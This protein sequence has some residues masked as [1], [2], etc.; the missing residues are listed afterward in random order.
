MV[1]DRDFQLPDQPTRA[2]ISAH[3]NDD[4][5]QLALQGCRDASVDM[6]MA[7]QQIDGY[8]RSRQKLPSW[9]ET[10]GLV[11]P[12]HLSMEQCSS[13]MTAHYKQQLAA[14]WKGGIMADLTGGFGVDFAHLATQFERAVYVER[15]QSLCEIASHNFKLLGLNHAEVVC[16]DAIEY[17]ST[18]DNHFDLL[19]IDPARRD[20]HGRKTFDLADCTPDISRHADTLLAKADRVMVKLSPM[21]DWHRA[22]A[23]LPSVGEVHIVATGNECKELLIVMDK[24]ATALTVTCKN[25]DEIF[26]FCPQGSQ[27][28][29][30]DTPVDSV[31]EW[32]TPEAGQ[33]LFVPN[34]AIMKAGCFDNLCAEYHLQ[35]LT[36]NSHLYTK[37]TPVAAFPG[38][39]F[40]LK[41]VTSL[42]KKSLRQALGGITRANIATRNFPM[43][44]QQLRSRLKLADG[45]DTYLFATTL[46]DG[47]HVVL[48]AEKPTD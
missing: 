5:R 32:A 37:D 21:F 23:E 33:Y 35:A 2:F 3:R 26:V 15:Q 9:A 13:E 39:T 43:T 14:R 18:T 8:Q 30:D 10:E 45:G 42:N 38:R 41:A 31:A 40:R 25:D 27:N 34:A 28:Q 4:V 12:P 47:S 36:T 29:I 20:E 16:A 48:I 7:L 1:S 19:Y 44:A 11:F 24:R 6:A 17:L 22:A 46:A